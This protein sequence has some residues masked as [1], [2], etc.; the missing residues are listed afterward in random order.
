MTF[1]F[2]IIGEKNKLFDLLQHP[3]Y[4]DLNMFV[5]S[6]NIAASAMDGEMII[7]VNHE[8]KQQR[9]YLSITNSIHSQLNVTS[10]A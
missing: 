5:R 8:P 9:F 1:C 3:G 2:K 7:P 6:L 4:K 10:T